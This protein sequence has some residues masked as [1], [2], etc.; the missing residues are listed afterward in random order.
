MT[1]RHAEKLV[2]AKEAEIISNGAKEVKEV[3]EP[4]QTKE[5]K[6]APVTKKKK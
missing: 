3:K 4:I 5:E 1:S 6:K 2:A